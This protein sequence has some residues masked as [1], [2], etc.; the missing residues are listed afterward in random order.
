MP[1]SVQ[2]QVA[3]LRRS[4]RDSSTFFRRFPCTSLASNILVG[5]V[6][7]LQEFSCSHNVKYSSQHWAHFTF[8][9]IYRYKS[10][11]N[12]V[13]ANIILARSTL[14]QTVPNNQ[15]FQTSFDLGFK[16]HYMARY[17]LKYEYLKYKKALHLIC[18]WH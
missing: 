5:W 6:A 14:V 18:K 8:G 3:S 13:L 12:V 9:E 4:F 15:P 16:A 1:V 2:S 17:R 11:E 7:S 10:L